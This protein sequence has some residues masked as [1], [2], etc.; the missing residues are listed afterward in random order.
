VTNATNA[1]KGNK[2]IHFIVII[3]TNA[4]KGNNR[5]SYT[6]TNVNNAY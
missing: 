4:K 3:V 5:I 6:V 1:E 2:K